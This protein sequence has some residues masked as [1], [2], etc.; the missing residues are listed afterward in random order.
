MEPEG[1]LL[2]EGRSWGN[3]LVMAHCRVSREGQ[4]KMAS[5]NQLALSA[6]QF[7]STSVALQGDSPWQ[8]EISDAVSERDKVKFTVQTKVRWAAGL[9]RAAGQHDVEPLRKH[10]PRVLIA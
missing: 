2:A 1:F 3:A 10:H 4:D 6:P 7:S 9:G 8:V 5:A